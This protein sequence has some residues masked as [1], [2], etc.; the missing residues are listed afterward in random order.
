MRALRIARVELVAIRGHDDGMAR[1][2][3]DG[4]D[5]EAH[6][7]NR[8]WRRDAEVIERG[9]DR[10]N[11]TGPGVGAKLMRGHVDPQA[12]CSFTSR[13]SLA[14]LPTHPLRSIKATRIRC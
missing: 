1:M 11:D 13:R 7:A 14:F 3:I 10:V 5:S 2:R 9:S 12:R 6:R 8:R 4:D